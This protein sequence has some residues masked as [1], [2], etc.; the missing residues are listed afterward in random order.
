MSTFIIPVILSGV[1]T[2]L[3]IILL[4]KSLRKTRGKKKYD[5]WASIFSAFATLVSILNISIPKPTI[6]PLNGETLIHV[7]EVEI[8]FMSKGNNLFEVYYTLDGTEPQNG[9]KYNEP[10]TIHETTTISARNKFFVFWSDINKSQYIINGNNDVNRPSKQ[11]AYTYIRDTDE[12]IDIDNSDQE[13]ESVENSKENDTLESALITQ[14]ILNNAEISEGIN[15][16]EGYNLIAYINQYRLDNDI[17]GLVL[18]SE[19]EQLAQSLATNYA[20]NE[21]IY[22]ILLYPCINRRCNGAKNAE[23]AVS[24]WITGNDYISS[25]KDTL[26]SSDFT[27]IGGALYYMPDG[28]ENG[29]HYFWIVC[30]G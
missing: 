5:I 10:F 17:E 16:V 21:D 26:L 13:K 12:I 8:Y 4:L 3:T 19:L 20:N 24:D 11:N 9:I 18:D 27:K 30:F 15:I 6:Y 14:P 29:Y 7:N 28:D 2:I 23:K 22:E 1:F 25:E